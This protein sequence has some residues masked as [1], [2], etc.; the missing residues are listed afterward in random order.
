MTYKVDFHTHSVA[1]PD[2]ALTLKHYQ[3]MLERRTLDCI[4]VTDHN[5]IAMALQLHAELGD[6]IIVGEE[7]TAQEGEI[8]GLYLTEAI[9][10]QLSAAETIERIHA[11]GALAYIPHPFET[12]RKGISVAVLER[13]ASHVDIFEVCNGRAIFQNRTAQALDWAATHAVPGAAGSDAHGVSGWG[14][15]Y[16]LLEAMPTRQTLVGLLAT[17]SYQRGFPG[18]RGVLY[19]KFNRLRTRRGHA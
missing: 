1:S 8:I 16:T 11:Q 12:V 19:P 10:A 14:R 7:I 6:R 15:T 4:A 17:A 9:P 3:R 13:V 5:T 18:V 2:G